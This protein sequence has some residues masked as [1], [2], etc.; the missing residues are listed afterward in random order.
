MKKLVAL[1]LAAMMILGCS[2]AFA[3][4]FNVTATPVFFF[5]FL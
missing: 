5:F 1:I 4:F 2:S 3:V